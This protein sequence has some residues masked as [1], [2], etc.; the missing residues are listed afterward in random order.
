MKNFIQFLNESVDEKPTDNQHLAPMDETEVIHFTITDDIL[1]KS[2]LACYNGN[3]TLTKDGKEHVP[4]NPKKFPD[5]AIDILIPLNEMKIEIFFDTKCKKWD[6]SFVYNGT[7]GKLSPD[8]FEQFFESD[9]YAKMLNKL[10]ELWPLSD[11]FHAELYNGLLEKEMKIADEQPIEEDADDKYPSMRNKDVTGDGKRDYSAS[12]RKIMHFADASVSI[13]SGRFFCWPNEKKL[14][15]W[16]VWKDWRKIKPLCRMR[17]KYINDHEYG[18]SLSCIGDQYE[19]R[20][21]RS[22]DLTAQP[23]LQWLSKEENDDLMNLSIF[24]RFIRHCREKIQKYATMDPQQIYD[25]IDKKDRITI[26]EIQ[27]TQYKV[28]KTLKKIIIPK[29]SDD[30]K[31]KH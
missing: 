16:S 4:V 27:E 5:K 9:F 12:G 31:W 15:R 18:I 10:K 2:K 8:Q 24:N 29:Q 19:H 23:P 14:N 26:E 6:S 30:Y 11:K 20:G 17:F 25:Q 13:K 28:L 22:Y 3:Q 7:D 21:F 1:N